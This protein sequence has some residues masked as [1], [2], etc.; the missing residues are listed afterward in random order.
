MLMAPLFTA[1]TSSVSASSRPPPR[2]RRWASSELYSASCKAAAAWGYSHQFGLAPLWGKVEL[3]RLRA[4][5]RTSATTAIFDILGILM[6]R[7]DM[8]VVGHFFA[9]ETVGLYGMAQQ[10]LTLPDKI[11][12]SF[13]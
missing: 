12:K 9:A 8:F 2:Q 13:V 10:F 11:A 6:A 1:N 4:M 7:L 5:T 3:L